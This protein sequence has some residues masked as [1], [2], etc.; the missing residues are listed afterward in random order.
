MALSLKHLLDHLAHLLLLLGRAGLFVLNL[1]KILYE[2]QA[3][4]QGL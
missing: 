1:F 4:E 3:M 2:G